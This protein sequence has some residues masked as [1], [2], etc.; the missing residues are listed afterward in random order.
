MLLTEHDWNGEWMRLQQERCWDDSPSFWD[1]RA[2]DF[3]SKAETSSYAKDFLGYAQIE[4]GASI[5]DFGCGTGALSLPLAREGHQVVAADFSTEMLSFLKKRA[6]E[7]G[8]SAIRA[9]QVSW[10]DDWEAAGIGQADIAIAS[11][12]IAVS[13]LGLALRKLDSA[14]RQRV[15]LT[16]AAGRG[17]KHDPRIFAA[18][19]RPAQQD[20]YVYCLNI[21][22]QM[23]IKPELRFIE[24][25]KKE[26]FAAREDAFEAV[27]Q[28]V[29]GLKPHEEEL[30]GAYLDEHLM[31]VVNGEGESGWKWDEPRIVSWAFISWRKGR[32]PTLRSSC[33]GSEGRR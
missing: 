19:G 17:P 22:F 25:E 5:L 26:F 11:R 1:K 9:V 29:N 15:C 33:C 30:L 31:P 10:E 24:S 27:S 7:E 20:G 28:M 12:S 3:A 8:L 32:T 14:A 4:P 16:I 2:P 18:L 13:D 21:L 23:G 6:A